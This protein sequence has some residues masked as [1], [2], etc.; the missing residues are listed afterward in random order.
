MMGFSIQRATQRLGRD[1]P[2]S[3]EPIELDFQ[4]HFTQSLHATG[5]QA[6][7]VVV[8][9]FSF[10]TMHLFKT[11]FTSVYQAGYYELLEVEVT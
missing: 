7:E 10:V 8:A 11:I 5:G 6:E 2:T 4:L 1:V 9:L 3:L